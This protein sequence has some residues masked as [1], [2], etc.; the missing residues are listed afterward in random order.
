VRDELIRAA[1]ARGK[2]KPAYASAVLPERL[3][4]NSDVQDG[5]ARCLAGLGIIWG[6][7]KFPQFHAVL[8]VLASARAS[9][10]FG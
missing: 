4:H 9:P 7:A 1:Q 5:E 6:A 2:K 3:A 10:F 8:P